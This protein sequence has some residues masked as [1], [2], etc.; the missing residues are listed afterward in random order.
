MKKNKID[1]D[2]DDEF[3][4]EGLSWKRKFKILE[5]K[6]LNNCVVQMEEMAKNLC[7]GKRV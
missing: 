7:Y 5:E 1:D 4:S 3:I 2:D 6:L